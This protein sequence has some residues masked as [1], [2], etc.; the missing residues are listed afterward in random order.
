MSNSIFSE[1]SEK[2]G[3]AEE[4]FSFF[5]IWKIFQIY[6]I[7]DKY[8]RYIWYLTNIPDTFDISE[9][10]FRYIWYIWTIFHIYLTSEKYSGYILHLKSIP[11]IFL[12][13][14]VAQELNEE[15]RK[16]TRRKEFIM[17]ELL[18]TERSYVKVSIL[19]R[20]FEFEAM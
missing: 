17:A 9:Q 2:Y 20:E 6:L 16:S 13:Y 7:F 15:K 1:S 18:E 3:L 14:L 8:S 10:Y 19:L 12:N 4:R 11:D 5:Y